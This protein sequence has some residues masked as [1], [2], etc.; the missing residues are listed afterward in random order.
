[1][2]YFTSNDIAYKNHFVITKIVLSQLLFNTATTEYRVVK[3]YFFRVHMNIFIAIQ[4]LG[5]TG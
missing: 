4:T 3:Y 5:I 1:M 2:N